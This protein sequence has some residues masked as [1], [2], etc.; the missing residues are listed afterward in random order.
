MPTTT[1]RPG[2]RPT[3]LNELA[4]AVSPAAAVQLKPRSYTNSATPAD[5]PRAVSETAAPGCSRVRPSGRPARPVRSPGVQMEGLE[6]EVGIGAVADDDGAIGRTRGP[7]AIRAAGC[8]GRRGGGGVQRKGEPSSLSELGGCWPDDD[9]ALAETA[10]AWLEGKLPAPGVKAPGPTKA[11]GGRPTEGLEAAD[12]VA[13]SHDGRAVGRHGIRDARS[14]ASG[15]GSQTLEDRG[16]WPRPDGMTVRRPRRRHT[17]GEGE[18][19]RRYI[20]APIWWIP[21]KCRRVAA[22]LPET[23]RPPPLRILAQLAGEPPVRRVPQRRVAV[24]KDDD[25]IGP[26]RTVT[27]SVNVSPA[28]SQRL[29][30]RPG[31]SRTMLGAGDARSRAGIGAIRMCFSRRPLGLLAMPAT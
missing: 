26:R 20:G 21:E 1:R 30:M 28:I 19:G 6:A 11:P 23:C 31:G 17:G 15:Q 3:G 22:N 24:G 12:R 25:G 29:A 9:G 8:Q 27:W 7:P 13:H 16:H 18:G 14:E 2:E 4:N 5:H 10:R